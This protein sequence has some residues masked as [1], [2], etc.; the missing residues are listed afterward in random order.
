MGRKHRV[1]VHGCGQSFDAYDVLGVLYL[2]LTN[3]PLTMRPDKGEDFTIPSS[4]LHAHA[5]KNTDRVLE[6]Y[7]TGVEY[8]ELRFFPEEDEQVK[9]LQD[10]KWEHPEIIMIGSS[11]AAQAYP[12]HIVAPIPVEDKLRN[13]YERKQLVVYANRFVAY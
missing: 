5:Q 1:E 8:R 9:I 4:G 13:D 11:I 7:A 6:Q 3:H 2:N 10:I 12:R